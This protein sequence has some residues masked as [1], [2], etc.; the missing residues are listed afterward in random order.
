MGNGRTIG[1]YT[2]KWL[3]HTPIPLT[4]AALDM[5][6]CELMDKDT[7]QWDG[8]SSKLCLVRGLNMASSF[9]I[10][11][12]NHLQS[13]DILIWTKNVAQKFSVKIAYQVALRMTTPAWVEHFAARDD[14]TIWNKI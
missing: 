1:V 11:P 14:G 8:G 10:I 2:H 9:L 6:V 7:R 5:R 4:E 3:T 12:F 13:Q